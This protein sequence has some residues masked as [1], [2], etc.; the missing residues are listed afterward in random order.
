[1]R[2]GAPGAVRAGG[3]SRMSHSRQP[4][5][6]AAASLRGSYNT[7]QRDSRT[8]SRRQFLLRATQIAAALDS[9]ARRIA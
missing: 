7:Y 5:A 4:G 8:M 1:M 2:P 3:V 9:I 6:R